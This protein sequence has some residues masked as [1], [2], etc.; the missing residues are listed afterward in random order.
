MKKYSFIKIEL[1][2]AFR[3][4]IDE[5]FDLIEF[6][7]EKNID[8]TILVVHS[9]HLLMSKNSNL[10]NKKNLEK[11]TFEIIFLNSDEINKKTKI[12]NQKG[13]LLDIA[14][15]VLDILT[16]NKITKM[17]LGFSLINKQGLQIPER[18]NVVYA[19]SDFLKEQQSLPKLLVMLHQLRFL[20]QLLYS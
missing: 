11:N 2:K 13:T 7:Q 1:E 15:T 17:G 19:Y 8:E 16:D 14:P 5:I 20:L 3:C 10:I 18:E 6:I 12:I 9:D 4:V